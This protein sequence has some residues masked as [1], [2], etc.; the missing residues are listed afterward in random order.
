M[1]DYIFQKSRYRLFVWFTLFI[2]TFIELFF[3]FFTSM[4]LIYLLNIFLFEVI[5]LYIL[6]LLINNEGVQIIHQSLPDIN[7]ADECIHFIEQEKYFRKST[8]MQIILAKAYFYIGNIEKSTD[9]LKNTLAFTKRKDFKALIY[10]HLTTLYFFENQYALGKET[11]EQAKKLCFQ[12]SFLK[13][14]NINLKDNYFHFDQQL[15]YHNSEISIQDYMMTLKTSLLKDN[16]NLSSRMI[17]RYHLANLYIE[18]QQVEEAIKQY[19]MMERLTPHL[20]VVS[21]LKQRLGECGYE[22]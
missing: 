17:V 18:L 20:Y 10:C 6:F 9:I 16:L 4:S 19:H 21:L 11:L 7:L 1:S 13:N 3:V 8:N 15:A 2:F 5:I 12:S 14:A 22:V